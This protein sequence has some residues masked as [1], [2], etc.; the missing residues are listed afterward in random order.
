MKSFLI[1][2][3]FMLMGA[4]YMSLVLCFPSDYFVTKRLKQRVKKI[5]TAIG[6]IPSKNY[7]TFNSKGKA[8]N[9][10][11]IEAE[12]PKGLKFET[13]PV[14]TCF[15]V[16]I[17]NEIVC[18]VHKLSHFSRDKIVVEFSY[19]R[20]EYEINQLIKD[21][22]RVALKQEKTYWKNRSLKAKT[23]SNSFYK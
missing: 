1:V 17:D 18:K 16:L 2:F 6:R 8:F 23:S 19:N 20:S 22:Y 4:L 9:I 5:H 12:V 14:Y 7:L 21:A 11:V 10:K 13:S 15:D 3:F